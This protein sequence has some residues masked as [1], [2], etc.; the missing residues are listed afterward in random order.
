MKL[1]NLTLDNFKRFTHYEFNPEGHNVN[2]YAANYVGKTSLMD[3]YFWLWLGKESEDQSVKFGIKP[4]NAPDGVDTVVTGTFEHNGQIF[5]L[6]RVLKDVYE[7]EKGD[8]DRKVKSI[9]T[10]FY[11]DDVPTGTKKEFDNFRFKI[12]DDET[13]LTLTLPDYFAEKVNN[14]DR[15]KKILEYSNADMDDR[16]IM[17]QYD[18]YH[19]LLHYMGSKSVEQYITVTKSQRKQANE[20]LDQIKSEINGIIMGKP[21]V[22]PEENDGPELLRLSKTKIQLESNLQKIRNGES[23][24]ALRKKIAELQAD[25]ST[26]KTAYIRKTAG[27]NTVLEA[28]AAT[29]RST[30]SNLRNSIA[31][32]Q[33]SIR[34]ATGVAEGLVK[35][36]A[37]LRAQ[38][39]TTYNLSFDVTN[40]ICPTCGQEYPPEKQQ[41][42]LDTFNENKAN[43]LEELEAK[44]KQLVASKS[45]MEAAAKEHNQK[46]QDDEQSLKNSES[47]LEQ[48]NKSYAN[49]PAFETTAEYKKLQDELSAAEHDLSTVDAVAA[50]QSEKLTA[51]L[52]VVIEQIDAIKQRMANKDTAARSDRLVSEREAEEK[53]LAQEM[54]IYD[55]GLDLVDKFNHFKAELISDKINSPFALVKWQMFNVRKNSDVELICEATVHG[56]TYNKGAINGFGDLSNSEKLNAGLDIINTLGHLT[57]VSVPVWIDNAESSTSPY[58]INA[59]V[60]QLRVSAKDK[61]LRA[62]VRG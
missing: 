34:S 12:C 32:S 31:K 4:N 5:T 28:E 18:E 54:A 16:S 27:G 20:R 10:E 15:R 41:G 9:K 11:I 26:A 46:L 57:G 39:V 25:I 59:Q 60:I 58:P 1:L 42:L 37:E 35:E 14:T 52:A 24:A 30:I 47:R 23:A 55:N 7:R 17:S 43:K 36:I 49:P 45:E 62:E 6:K 29:L 51:Q 22:L 2:V 44:G 33:A 13:F 50:K 3:A 8:A 61:Q 38:C 40:N 19:S 21:E 53:N 48:L 56:C